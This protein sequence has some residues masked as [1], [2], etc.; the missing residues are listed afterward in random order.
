MTQDAVTQAKE[1]T[2]FVVA[3]DAAHAKACGLDE[4]LAA[5]DQPDARVWINLLAPSPSDLVSI[6]QKLTIHELAIE[7]VFSPQSH[8]KIEPYPSNL[9]CVIPALNLT[10]SDDLF[11]VVNLNAFLGR[12]YIVTAE[13]CALPTIASAKEWIVRSSES[14]RRGPDFLLYQLLDVIVD[15]YLELTDQ[16]N[17]EIDG[18]EERIFGKSD[19][20]VS[21]AIFELRHKAAWL[22]RLISPQREILNILTNR[23]HEGVPAA[24]AIVSERSIALIGGGAQA[25]TVLDESGRL[26][27]DMPHGGFITVV[28]NALEAARKRHGVDP[29]RPVRIVEYANGRLTMEDPDTGTSF[30]LYA[31]GGDNEA[32]F[33]D[34]LKR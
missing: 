29:D 2:C 5:V 26:L 27:A 30:E 33:R 23:P 1:I 3:G 11:D 9:F 32:A 18:L 8:A 19:N 21:E 20:S 22:R 31:F 14:L 7:D 4:A 15:E 16:M 24:A 12:N 28:Q 13:R 6:A 10:T 34:L 25:V 17:S